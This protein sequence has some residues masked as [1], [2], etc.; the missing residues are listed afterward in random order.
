MMRRETFF[1]RLCSMEILLQAHQ[2]ARKNKTWYRDVKLVDENPEYFLRRIQNMLLTKSYEV[3]QY[4]EEYRLENG[5][6]RHL[7]KLPYFPD[8][9]IQWAIILVTREILERKFIYTTFSSIPGRGPVSCMNTVVRDIKHDIE[10]TKYCLKL[11]IHHFYESIDHM[12]LKSLYFRIFKDEDL[13][14][15]IFKIIDS[16]PP[17][18]GIPIGNFLSQYSGNL[19]LTPL[20]HMCKEQLFCK[21]YYRYMDDI[22][23]LKNDKESLWNILENIKHWCSENK[24]SIKSNYQIFPIDIRGIDFVGYRIFPTHVLIRKRIIKNMKRKVKKIQIH[25]IKSI[26]HIRGIIASYNGILKHGNGYQLH[27]KY[28]LDIERMLNDGRSQNITEYC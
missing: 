13:L 4:K 28:L 26:T 12:I 7:Y 21:Y 2:C 22:V 23:I 5:K 24:L 15:L 20:D 17:K 6:T 11:D 8:R 27:Q 19:F 9:I 14:E 18:D 25:K 10:G 1:D 16:L 3:S